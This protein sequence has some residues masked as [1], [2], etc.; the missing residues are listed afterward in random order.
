[1]L[2]G[3]CWLLWLF[4]CLRCVSVRFVSG[5]GQPH[6]C[7]SLVS[8]H[9]R[10]CWGYR[11]RV[12]G[13]VRPRSDLDDDIMHDRRQPQGSCFHVAGDLQETHDVAVSLVMARGHKIR[14]RAISDVRCHP[15][16]SYSLLL[17]SSCLPVL[18]L[19][20]CLV[21]ESCRR[22]QP[23][24]HRHAPDRHSVNATSFASSNALKS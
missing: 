12:R 13:H 20:H 10:I 4:H 17:S 3:L 7:C 5:P 15:K 1:M 9:P 14:G 18:V 8:W 21:L 11:V 2:V 16:S 19:C 24:F 23:A 22:F 6:E